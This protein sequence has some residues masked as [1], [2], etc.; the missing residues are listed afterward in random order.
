[1]NAHLSDFLQH[2]N[3]FFRV[4]H[5]DAFRYLE[6]QSVRFKLGLSQHIHDD[7]RKTGLLKLGGRDVHGNPE[8][9]QPRIAPYPVLLTSSSYDPRTQLRDEACFFSKWNKFHWRN[10]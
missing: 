7:A 6:L 3:G 8:F 10:K 2:E 9:W 1:M 4:A 5:D